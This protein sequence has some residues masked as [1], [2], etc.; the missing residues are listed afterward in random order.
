MEKILIRINGV[1]I[2]EIKGKCKNE[3]C[4]AKQDIQKVADIFKDLEQIT[5]KNMENLNLKESIAKLM[6][7]IVRFQL[8]KDLCP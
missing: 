5:V 1:D 4:D 7:N 8:A 3:W 2:C 6:R